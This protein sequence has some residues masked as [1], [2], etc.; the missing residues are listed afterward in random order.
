MEGDFPDKGLVQCAKNPEHR[1]GRNQVFCALG[2]EAGLPNT[3]PPV[4]DWL[5]NYFHGRRL[6][7]CLH[8]AP[9]E[10]GCAI[11]AAAS[12]L[13]ECDNMTQNIS[14]SSP[15]QV[16]QRDGLAVTSKCQEYSQD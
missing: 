8:G 6:P 10:A 3:F 15:R 16:S 9:E 11:L 4:Q 13:F 2:H 12:L 1:V 7:A 5:G 14:R